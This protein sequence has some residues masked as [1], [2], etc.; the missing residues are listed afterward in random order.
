MSTVE[1]G[2]DDTAASESIAQKIVEAV[3]ETEGVDPAELT[4]S[5]YEILDPDALNALFAPT[6]A[7]HPR[8]TGRVT[9]Q[10]CGYDV[11]ASSDGHVS[12]DARNEPRTT[13]APSRD[14]QAV[15]N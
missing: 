8:S 12:V 5:L 10:Y 9:F 15:D 11:T 1:P 2:G 14:S 4:P 3:A 6:N 13:N 7:G